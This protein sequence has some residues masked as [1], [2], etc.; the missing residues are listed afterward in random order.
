MDLILKR[1]SLL[2][3]AEV[4]YREQAEDALWSIVPRQQKRIAR[5][6]EAWLAG[7]PELATLD[8]RFDAII[9]DADG[10]TLHI[11]D[12]FRPEF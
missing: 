7:N 2:V 8:M 9:V 10:V 1:K 4:K 12:A 5:A 6:A 11:E 3:F